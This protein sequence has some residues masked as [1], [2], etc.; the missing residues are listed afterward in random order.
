MAGRAGRVLVA[1]D[2]AS[3]RRSLE[4]GLRL[5]GFDVALADDGRAALESLDR[6]RPDVVVLDVCMPGP[7]GIDICRALRESGDDIPVLMVSALD[8]VGDRIAGL[9][10]GGDDYLVKPYSLQELTLRLRALLRR[11]L[12]AGPGPGPL[13]VGGLAVDAAGH[14]ASL[15][16]TRLHLTPREFRL[17]ET[18]A[19][20]QGMVLTRRQLLDLVWG[21]DT[22]VRADAVDTYVS[23]LRRK[24]ESDGRPRILHTVHG[25]GF[26]LRA[27]AAGAGAPAPS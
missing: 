27:E 13:R 10:A 8:Q 11:R 1:D 18:L 2:D 15:D 20:H 19:K 21:P 17:L 7:T 14:R 23:Y 25:V 4:R 24:T 26:V 22:R 9:Q 12:P 3:T 6:F 5:G 16:G